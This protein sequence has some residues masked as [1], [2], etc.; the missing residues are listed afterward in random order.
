MPLP[1]LT[2]GPGVRRARLAVQ[3]RTVAHMR[4][5]GHGVSS[6]AAHRCPLFPA[7][8]APTRNRAH[9]CS[10]VR[11]PRRRRAAARLVCV[12]PL[13]AR[14]RSSLERLG[15]STGR[16]ARAHMR[17]A[18]SWLCHSAPEK[19]THQSTQQ[20]GAVLHH[21][22][23]PFQLVITPPHSRR[24]SA[25]RELRSAILPSRACGTQAGD[26]VRT[27]LPPRRPPTQPPAW[28]AWPRARTRPR[29][30][31]KSVV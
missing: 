24:A 3:A 14:E 29:R 23:P 17:R 2:P 10:C 4:V 1:T 18:A 12:S 25:H 16:G 6:S 11:R 8:Q 22:A 5:S 31:R 15:C 28:S 13:L 9:M 7:R 19:Q 21:A 27:P 26:R 20:E 30:D